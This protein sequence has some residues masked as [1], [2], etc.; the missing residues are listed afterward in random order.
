MNPS[1]RPPLDYLLLMQLYSHGRSPPLTEL[2][3]LFTQAGSLFSS[4]PSL[5]Y[6]S[7]PL[8]IVGDLHGQL[9][10]LYKVLELS[11]PL[12]A[13]K[14][15]FLGDYVDRGPS[16]LEIVALLCALK[17]RYPNSVFLLRGNH[18]TR[19]ATTGYGFREECVRKYNHELWLLLMGVFDKLPLAAVIN[20]NFF[21]VHGGISPHA[22]SI[23]AINQLNREIEPPLEGAVTDL[24]WS[25]PTEEHTQGGLEGFRGGEVEASKGWEY[26]E[27][28]GCGH[29]FGPKET[30]SFLRE[31][32]LNVIIR[33]HQCVDNGFDCRSFGADFPVVITL[34]SAEDYCGAKN[35][36]AMMVLR[37][38]T[39]NIV[40]FDFGF[41]SREKLFEEFGNAF[42]W[43]LPFFDN[44]LLQV[45]EGFL[46]FTDQAENDNGPG[47]EELSKGELE[48]LGLTKVGSR[49]Q[50]LRACGV[51]ELRGPCPKSRR[52]LSISWTPETLGR[53]RAESKSPEKKNPSLLSPVQTPSD[54]FEEVIERK[55]SDFF[56][57]ASVE[58]AVN[59]DSLFE[60]FNL[61]AEKKRK[62]NI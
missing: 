28:R 42:E 38:N 7:D 3:T 9:G 32:N 48:T 60:E 26:N 6:L 45:V 24:I 13:M 39:M 33:A 49:V 31:N 41:K 34:F 40:Q 51:E 57:R 47:I 35:L 43:T 29:L 37:N 14:F 4:E 62:R 1:R 55:R 19:N 2:T 23:K 10:D 17:I 16:G 18:E 52:S 21:A 11:G 56:R 12:S 27:Q 46:E 22:T 50:G 15:L 58:L 8:T 44:L 20:G 30:F 54:V 59:E 5:L 61:G 25:D 53:N 36:G